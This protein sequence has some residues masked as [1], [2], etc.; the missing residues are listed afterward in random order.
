MHFSYR[1]GVESPLLR[2]DARV[3]EGG[4]L[5]RRYT[6]KT[7]IEGSNPSHSA[8][9]SPANRLVLRRAENKPRERHYTNWTF[10]LMV[11]AKEK[12][13]ENQPALSSLGVKP[14]RTSRPRQVLIV[15]DNL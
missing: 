14:A 9:Q 5:L 2:S 10:E 8:N 6:G 13:P 7:R 3:A 12:P 11:V 15:E 1:G 4:A